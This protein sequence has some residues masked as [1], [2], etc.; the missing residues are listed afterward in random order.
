MSVNLLFIHISCVARIG[1]NEDVRRPLRHY[2]LQKI[3]K[4]IKTTISDQIPLKGMSE[5]DRIAA[6]KIIKE[7]I[8][9][10]GYLICEPTNDGKNEY[11]HRKMLKNSVQI[12]S[13]K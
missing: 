11:G 12:L 9:V 1:K 5:L 2:T 10:E 4:L 13:E 3:Q 7:R 8:N 6:I